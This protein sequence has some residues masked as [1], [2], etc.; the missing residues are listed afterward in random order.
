MHRIEATKIIF[1]IPGLYFSQDSGLTYQEHT[2][3]CVELMAKSPQ[4]KSSTR[5]IYLE[6]TLFYA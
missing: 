3:D 5:R 1:T 4:K 6:E 2:L